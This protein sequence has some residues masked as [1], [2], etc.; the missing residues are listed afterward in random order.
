MKPEDREVLLVL[1][2]AEREITS[3]RRADEIHEA[4]KDVFDVFATALGLREYENPAMQ[5][6]GGMQD[7]VWNL[8]RIADQMEQQDMEMPR[9][10]AAPSV[11]TE[12]PK[13]MTEL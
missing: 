10:P 11:Q 6:Q 1:R 5:L 3:L 9:G 8:R 4:R 7:V 12:V 13:G 2:Q